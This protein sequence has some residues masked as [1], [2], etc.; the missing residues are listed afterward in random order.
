MSLRS[1]PAPANPSGDLGG[2]YGQVTSSIR[3][4]WLLRAEAVSGRT[5]H[6]AGSVAALER[7]LIAA[8]SLMVGDAAE[9]IARGNIGRGPAIHGG[10][11][12]PA[13]WDLVFRIAHE[14]LLDLAIHSRQELWLDLG[15]ESPPFSADAVLEAWPKLATVLVEKWPELDLG[16]VEAELR[17][18]FDR[19]AVLLAERETASAQ[20]PPPDNSHADDF[21]SLRR[22]GVT[23]GPFTPAQAA[24]LRCLYEHAERGSP[25]VGEDKLL[26]AID[27]ERNH[28]ATP[29]RVLFH[30][31][32]AWRRLIVSDGKGVYRLAEPNEIAAGEK[33]A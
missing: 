26:D 8:N 9:A 10:Q 7:S 14:G 33:T 3:C 5:W 13:W 18:E 1:G 11:V 28:D 21:R 12:S 23:F 16:L 19:A 15:A 24:V 6:V 32:P 17:L 31:H 29:L 25:H 27:P 2:A 22:G 20:Q 30:G 4:Y